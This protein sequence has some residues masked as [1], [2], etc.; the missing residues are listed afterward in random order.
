MP[1]VDLLI[2]NGEVVIPGSGIYRMDV[3]VSGGKVVHLGENLD[4]S[5][6]EVIDATGKYVMP[7]LMDPHVHLGIFA[8]FEKEV[9]TETMSALIG[10]IT[11]VGCFMGGPD[12]Y[13]KTFG[14][15]ISMT[16][17]KSRVDIVFHLVINNEIQQGEIEDY[18]KEF[19]VTSFKQY[20]CGIPG[21]IPSVT[22]D[23]MLTTLEKV[24][25]LGPN[26]TVCVHAE[27]SF[28]VDKA[29]KEV[30][31]RGGNTLADLA[32]SHP[33]YAEEEAVVRGSFLAK[34]AGQRLYFVHISTKEAAAALRKI[35]AEQKNIFAET[36]SPYLSINK[37]TEKGIVAHMLP[38][39][40][41]QESV[42]GLWEALKDDVIDTIGTDNVTLTLQV[43]GAE[44]G[45]W[46][47][48][49][50]YPA[51]GT[52]L[53]VVLNEGVHKRGV[54][55]LKVAEKMSMNPA[56]VFGLYPRK[57]TLLPGSDA[58]ITIVDLNLEKVVRH[59]ELGSYA[60]F[61]LYDGKSLKGWPVMTI[62]GGKVAVKE[63][64][65]LSEPGSGKFIRRSPK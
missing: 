23:F 9:E 11:T 55:L 39:F 53:P 43:K 5:A 27:N 42:E 24:R 34:L 37:Y 7:G 47:A 8:P 15:I 64:K 28:L 57:G 29:T 32:D 3:A 49:P 30:Q 59:E 44:K 56:K 63:G 51:V 48:M 18:C 12:S 4:V 31:A 14:D 22:D 60:D 21:L 65:V 40:R 41:E 36:T 1:S 19:G 54:S 2:K 52:S 62:K 45:I 20:M 58:D 13:L 10:G 17:N 6:G 35:K 33:N 38:P 25:A 46:G 26:T 16:N 61:S 50:G